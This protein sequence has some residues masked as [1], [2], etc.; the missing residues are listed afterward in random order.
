MRKILL[1]VAVLV[2]LLIVVAVVVPFLIPADVYKNKVIA[3]VKTATGRDLVIAGPVSIHILPSLEFS[4]QQVSLS[5]PQGA[6]AMASIAKL[7]VGV[8]LMPLL[9]HQV[10]VDH[11][12]LTQPVIHAE[13]DQAGHPNWKFTQ[14]GPATPASAAKPENRDAQL[15]QLSLGSVRIVDGTVTYDDKRSGKKQELDTLNVSFSLPSFGEKLSLDGKAVWQGQPVT[16]SL[17]ADNLRSALLSEPTPAS[18]T[19]EGMGHK[20]DVKGKLSLGLSLVGL[21]DLNLTIDSL[22]AKGDLQL[23]TGAAV[24]SIKGT[25]AF[26]ALDL[27][28][29][30]PQVQE[31]GAAVAPGTAPA[32]P[33]AAGWSDAPLDFS[34]L[35]AVDAALAISTGSITY[36]KITVGKT[37]LALALSEGRLS[38]DL[39]QIALYNGAGSGRITLDGSAP[40]AGVGIAFTAGKV[41]IQPLLEAAIGMDKLSGTGDLTIDVAG[42]GRSQRE[43][44]AALGGKGALHVANGAIKGVDLAALI[45]NT[46]ATLEKGIGGGETAFSNMGGSFTVANGIMSNSDLSLTSAVLTLGGTGEVN[47][48]QRTLSYRLTPQVVQGASNRIDKMGGL[49]VPII[50]SGPWDNLTYRPDVAAVVQQKLAGKVQNLLANGGGNSGK[51]ANLLKQFLK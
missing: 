49:E 40:G 39:K 45:K 4:A 37:V 15:Q 22:K 11:L 12:T 46:A 43:V 32:V 21:S 34:A 24:P 6:G 41:A 30:L 33:S 23:A 1:G 13:I 26:D 17:S 42:R 48:P 18:L 27:N 9:S 35:K 8:K 36:R 14:T 47:L 16:V 29:F 2:V 25:L 5:N 31:P 28:P 10:V 7:E 44:I 51:A 38:A 3:A 19:F 20:L 50:V